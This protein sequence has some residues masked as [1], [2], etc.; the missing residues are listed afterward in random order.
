MNPLTR[1]R[2]TFCV[3]AAAALFLMAKGHEPIAATDEQPSAFHFHVDAR[4]ALDE[5]HEAKFRINRL[6]ALAKERRAEK[7][8]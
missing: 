3:S 8:S 5:F 2:D 1:T 7:L 6:V 4:A